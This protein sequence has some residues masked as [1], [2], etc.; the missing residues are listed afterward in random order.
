MEPKTSPSSS[1][2]DRDSQPAN[3]APQ[4]HRRARTRARIS[5]A[6]VRC[7]KR[8][9]RCDGVLPSC[10]GCQKAGVRCVDG[11][12]SRE[13][14]RNY[15]TELE[16]R[17]AWLESVVR[18][19][20][21][22][23]DLTTGPGRPSRAH[24]SAVER[25]QRQG[26]QD[27][28]EETSPHELT[29]Q[30]GLISISGG[31]D[32]RYL[33]PSSGL[34][35][36]KFV[37]AGLAHVA[38]IETVNLRGNGCDDDDVFLP[39]DLVDLQAKDFPNDKRQT[40]F[41][42]QIY[43]DSVHL[44]F[45]F[46]HEPS[47]HA[48][49]HKLY[50][51]ETLDALEEFQAFMVLAVGATIYGRRSRRHMLGEGY[52]ASALQRLDTV[53]RTPSLATVQCLLLLEMYTLHDPSSGLNL[54]TLHYHSLASCL[55]L[56]L[57]RDVR[58]PRHFNPLQVE[59]RTRI[60]W[61]TYTMNRQLCTIMGRPL[62]FFDEQCDLRLPMDV[63]DDDLTEEGVR[64]STKPPGSFTT[65]SSAIHL[66]KWAR[67]SSEIKTVL[68][69]TDRFYPP[70]MTPAINDVTAWRTDMISRLRKWRQDIPRHAEGERTFYLIDL[71]EIRYHELMMLMLRP[72]P[73][74]KQ[75]SKAALGECF[76]S[77]ITC[78]KL[79]AKLYADNQ[80][81]YGWL[82]VH[83][84]FLCIMTIFYCVWT[85]EGIAD[86]V[87]FDCL[88]TSLKAAS[89]VLSA[90]GEY[91]PEA[92][93]SRDVL[94]RIFTATMRR[95]SPRPEYPKLQPLI[96][97]SDPQPG[98][99]PASVGMT[100]GTSISSQAGSSTYGDNIAASGDGLIASA[101]GIVSSGV[102][103][104]EADLHLGL[105]MPDGSP[106]MN[107]EFPYPSTT[108]DSFMSTDWLSYFMNAEDF[109]GMNL[110]TGF[111]GLGGLGGMGGF[112]GMEMT[113]TDIPGWYQGDMS[114]LR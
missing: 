44:Q 46:L 24:S 86:Q 7:Q 85:P 6:C 42:T 52:Y 104:G 9:I 29:E 91:W 76:T 70:Y 51:G 40:M 22:D 71:C 66:F 34:F 96:N 16:S 82:T 48:I 30:I 53:F 14:P 72:N 26:S 47:H 2:P 49:L 87:N 41:L 113:G 73:L 88:T 3:F 10:S 15:L 92:K 102:S 19:R 43:F 89:D 110:D 58:N 95:F 62:G 18:E 93:R 99:G 4:P 17:V 67:F 111:G 107:A 74:F 80:L 12:T 8:K 112:G 32:L 57:H 65:M 63:N 13:I 39:G 1:N 105:S 36:T 108:L 60:F 56:G 31:S 79:Y 50:N 61:C 28:P 35:F 109:G 59:L 83:S 75:P 69:C 101:D 37:L 106:A 38:D 68:F 77:A 23:V 11:G 21:P 97:S 90:T 98:S 45:P 55:E 20:C 114:V 81:R 78:S 5:A 33:G 54:W 84:L 64:P 27:S 100:D 103:H 25:G 94:D